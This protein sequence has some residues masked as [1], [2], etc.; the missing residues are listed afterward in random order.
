MRFYLDLVS[1]VL[2]AENAGE[3][4][5]DT[6]LSNPEKILFALEEYVGEDMLELKDFSFC[7]VTNE[8]FYETL[9]D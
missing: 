6:L 2:E 1:L 8:F 5:S 4:T 3:L 7:L 9:F